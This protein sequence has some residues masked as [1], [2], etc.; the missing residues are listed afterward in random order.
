MRIVQGIFWWG[1]TVLTLLVLDDLL[2][3]PVF[4]TL[5]L[6]S[7]MLSTVAAF[8]ASVGF[9]TWLVTAGMR[10]HPTGIA[11]FFL[12]RLM[13]ERKNEKIAERERALR[14]SAASVIGAF[15]VAPL[16]GGVIPALILHKYNLMST[17][18][19][20]AFAFAL[21]VI[22]AFEFALIH[23]GYGIGALVRSVF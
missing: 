10:E 15:V 2:F 13:L 9:Q 11:S 4:W 12:R 6:V 3:G 19:L 1:M 22:Y 21:S 8:V 20:R 7:P 14:Y 18:R 17:V 16:V 23:G 5:A